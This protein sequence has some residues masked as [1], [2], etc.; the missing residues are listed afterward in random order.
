MDTA[1][2]ALSISAQDDRSGA[3]N[4][5]CVARSRAFELLVSEAPTETVAAAINPDLA[6]RVTT[7]L[8]DVDALLTPVCE[9][10]SDDI[11]QVIK[12]IGGFVAL[13]GGGWSPEDRQ[14]FL[15]QAVV[16]FG[17]LPASL[18]V[19]AI[20]AARKR[21]RWAREFVPWVHEACEKDVA[22]LETER[23]RIGWLARLADAKPDGESD[24]EA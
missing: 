3:P 4:R 7:A 24:D 10:P 11:E 17:D 18:C 5:Q 19:P 21:L 14:E 6:D 1:T 13:T 12:E 2:T 16:E 23:H 20:R 8:A 22:K 9:L 15:N